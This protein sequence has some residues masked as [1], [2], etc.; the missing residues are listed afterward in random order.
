[1]A[2]EFETRYLLALKNILTG[3]KKKDRTGAG[4]RS[5]FG[6]TF[7]INLKE[8]F[9]ILTTK[10]INFES[11]KKELLWFLRGETNINS[12]GS[13]IWNP[14]ANAHGELG[15]IYGKQWRSWPSDEG[16]I[17]QIEQVLRLI[18]EDPASRR[19]VV[20]AWNVADLP[21]MA[22]PPCHVLFQFY[23]EGENLSCSV[24]QRSADMF[25]GVPFNISSYS[26]L[27]HL[28]AIATS[29]YAHRL[30]WHGGDCHI[31]QNHLDQVELQLTREPFPPPGIL[32]TKEH[33][34]VE[35][36]SSNEIILLDYVHHSKINAE[37]SV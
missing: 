11:V 24:Y 21:K 35:N 12:L 23:V 29:K 19:I 32:I 30:V 17:D 27:L 33:E 10:E 31:Y 22:L 9:P 36:Y 2:H 7:D 6:I 13:K 4:T 3:S 37:V 34:K 14:W 25:L 20:S 15:P 18:R 5:K 16:P 26:L 28:V 8:G 1:M